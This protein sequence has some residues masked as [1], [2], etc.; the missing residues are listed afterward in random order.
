MEA[1][2]SVSG[3]EEEEQRE[4]EDE[5]EGTKKHC[6]KSLEHLRS[7]AAGAPEIPNGITL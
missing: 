4:A 2:L 1:R 7:D 6:A 3:G 5:R